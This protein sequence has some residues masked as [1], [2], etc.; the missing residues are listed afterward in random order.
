MSVCSWMC[1]GGHAAVRAACPTQGGGHAAV[2]A[3]CPASAFPLV[4]NTHLRRKWL[5]KGPAR[6][7]FWLAC[8]EYWVCP[9][10]VGREKPGLF[11]AHPEGQPGKLLCCQKPGTSLFLSKHINSRA[12][13]RNLSTHHCS[14]T[15]S[16]VAAWPSI[17]NGPTPG[18]LL[19][20]KQPLKPLPDSNAHSHCSPFLAQPQNLGTAT[21]CQFGMHLNLNVAP[22]PPA[23]VMPGAL[24]GTMPFVM[25][26]LEASTPVPSARE[27]Q[28][29]CCK[30]GD[31]ESS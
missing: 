5:S 4:T 10:W 27:E 29:A 14:V 26:N 16:V 11:C 1:V 12:R 13:R 18:L 23:L 2:R 19:H 20:A 15:P 6:Q 8:H 7:H 31:G 24:M 28:E 22:E 17:S 21:L 25:P 3:A 30:P 9:C